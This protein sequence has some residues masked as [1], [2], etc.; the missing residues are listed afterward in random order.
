[1]IRML[2]LLF[3]LGLGLASGSTQAAEP[4]SEKALLAVI[5]RS[6]MPLPGINAEQ[7]QYLISRVYAWSEARLGSKVRV[8]TEQNTY[9]LLKDNGINPADC[10]QTDCEV[11]IGRKI[12]A[13]WLI[14]TKLIR[15]D[16]KSPYI[17]QAGL[18]QTGTSAF[19]GS[20]ESKAATFNEMTEAAR[21]EVDKLLNRLLENLGGT[22]RSNSAQLSFSMPAGPVFVMRDGIAI[23][24]LPVPASGRLRLDTTPGT[25]TFLFRRD[26]MQ[27]V[28]LS[29][30][31]D[32]EQP[33]EREVVFMAGQ[34]KVLIKGSGTGILR[35]ASEPS[36]AQ[37]YL[38]DVEVGTTT[39]QLKDVAAG[40]HKVRLVKPL[41]R[42]RE[43][44]VTVSED[45]VAD[46]S[47]SLLPD[48]APLEIQTTPPGATVLINGQDKGRTP[49]R[50][51]R[52]QA[53]EYTL[54]IRL[55]LY[56][57]IDQPLT[58]EPGK[59]VQL[60]LD[61]QPAFGS[62]TV[63]S[64]PTGANVWVD[65]I[66]WGRTPVTRDRV[67]SGRH[68][69]RVQQELYNE[70]DSWVD[71]QDGGRHQVLAELGADFGTAR[72]TGTPSG[73]RVLV[74]G[75]VHGAIPVDLRLK[76]GEHRLTVSHENHDTFETKL[77]I[78]VG[79]DKEHR[80]DLV[81]QVGSLRIFVEPADALIFV[82]GQEMGR[83]PQICKDL[84][85]GKHR[86]RAELREHAPAEQEVTVVRDRSLDVNVK[87]SRTAW[88]EGVKRR[89]QALFS[90]MVLPGL[91]QT[92]FHQGR[93]VVYMLLAAGGAYLAVDGY[94]AYSKA[95]KLYTDERE[96]Y[97]GSFTQAAMDE[98][99]F[100]MEDA[101]Q[102]LDAA[103][104]RN[105]LGVAVLGAAWL[106]SVLDAWFWGGGL[107]E[108]RTDQAQGGP[109]TPWSVEPLV[110]A[111][112]LR[113]QVGYRW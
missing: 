56:H 69:V 42:V 6:A 97:V 66:S 4:A 95:D 106:G 44:L 85:T 64:R 83:S 46:V 65:E 15:F 87:L 71:V 8:M 2:L 70:Y 26:G 47:E 37:V 20:M 108:I 109:T 91:G 17:F 59:A 82:D 5:D 35:V 27:D 81:R 80:V 45:A 41:Y 86:V 68:T 32:S 90:S 53:G 10:I 103:Q 58:M 1:M 111:D 13:D 22:T 96:L 34:S 63:D 79:D 73:A 36:G 104:T 19:L 14:V 93:G 74:D 55:D 94:V 7:H 30:V 49:F 50:V 18:Y 84:P 62:L 31:A 29:V 16:D 98:H 39:L 9:T 76:P 24:T 78:G 38:D 54:R 72:I 11:A 33:L 88:L 12:G 25:H 113:L 105:R 43:V 101:W 112:G 61:L 100:A 60:N 77:F 52:Q 107:R 67:P 21:G 28:E 89:N 48:F 99:F 110:Q 92:R 102:D 51:E 23:G 75:E 57:D 40:S 3:L